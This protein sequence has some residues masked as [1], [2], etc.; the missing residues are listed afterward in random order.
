VS[1]A[2]ENSGPRKTSFASRATT[3][4]SVETTAEPLKPEGSPGL[5]RWKKVQPLP[6]KSAG[7]AD[8]GQESLPARLPSSLK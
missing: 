6:A 3:G 2:I 8:E 4:W 5:S 1:P 7:Q